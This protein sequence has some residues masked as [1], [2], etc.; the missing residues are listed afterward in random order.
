ML[1]ELLLELVR[2]VIRDQVQP[3]SG[4]AMKIVISQFGNVSGRW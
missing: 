1:A 3:I 4:H 2:R